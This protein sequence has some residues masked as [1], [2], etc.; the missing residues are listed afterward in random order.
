MT[1]LSS[2]ESKQKPYRKPVTHDLESK[3]LVQ[4]QSDN[5]VKPLILFLVVSCSNSCQSRLWLQKDW[6]VSSRIPVDDE[7]LEL[8]E[9]TAKKNPQI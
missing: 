5:C 7:K 1:S 6:L 9:R 4:D 2:L 8:D 3:G